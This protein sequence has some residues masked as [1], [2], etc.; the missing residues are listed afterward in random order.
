MVAGSPETELSFVV[1]KFVAIN[2]VNLAAIINF[3]IEVVLW[4]FNLTIIQFNTI[5]IYLIAQ[6]RM[7]KLAQTNCSTNYTNKH[8]QTTQQNSKHHLELRLK[9][10]YILAK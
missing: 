4:Q 6:R 8:K 1:F 2:N 3:E 5:F 9:L 7:T 10:K